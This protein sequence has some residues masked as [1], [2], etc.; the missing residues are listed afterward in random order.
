MIK[1]QW[2]PKAELMGMLL[3]ATIAKAAEYALITTVVY[4]TWRFWS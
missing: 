3:G 1:G 2:V 4:F